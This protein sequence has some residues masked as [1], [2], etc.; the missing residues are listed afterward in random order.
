MDRPIQA[1]SIVEGCVPNIGARGRTRRLIG[2]AVWTVATSA[3]FAVF[4][5]RHA[6]VVMFLVVAPFAAIASL[7]FYQV[8]EKT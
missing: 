5:T 1:V 7:N 2:G 4:A 6:P 8:K 3:V